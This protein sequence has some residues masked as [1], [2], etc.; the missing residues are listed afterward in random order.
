MQQLPL[1]QMIGVLRSALHYLYDPVHLR[2]SPLVA[3][4]GLSE[5]ADRAAALQTQLTA[6]V[7]AL[8]PADDEDPQSRA[9]RIYDLLHFQYVRQLSRDAVATQLGISLRQLRREQRIALE[10]LAQQLQLPLDQPDLLPVA[11]SAP[12]LIAN[13]QPTIV[14]Q[15]LNEELGWL[16]KGVEEAPIPLSD[17][18]HMVQQLVRPLAER[19]EVE[20][21]LDVA[22]ELAELPV[23]PLV[24][25][26]IL[27]TVL[28]VAIPRAGQTPIILAARWTQGNLAISVLAAGGDATP[29]TEVEVANLQT[30]EKLATFHHTQ[31]EL[32][33]IDGQNFAVTLT[34]PQPAQLQVLVI[35]DNP[36]WIE[37]QQR[38]AYNTRYQVIGTRDSI[39][40]A[41]IAAQMQPAVILLDVMIQAAD[42]WQILSELR[43]EPTTVDIPVIICT[44]L[45]VA[46]LALALGANAFLPKPVSQERYLKMLEHW[47]DWQT[48]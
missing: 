16:K 34:L 43:H 1:D 35:D 12:G 15:A 36:D 3:S 44:I 31:L 19:R 48:G 9:W 2:S 5:E 40:A 21:Q 46:D 30:A 29:L 6:A 27:L 17:A 14:D 38:Y 10:V 23:R 26:S 33:Q 28:S 13:A 7:R 41:S 39:Q 45:P 11:H 47:S 4:L 22:V 8:K 18:L 42:G 37:L 32:P 20:L 25:R 24:L